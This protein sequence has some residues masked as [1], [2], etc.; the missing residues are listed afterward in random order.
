MNTTEHT[1]AGFIAEHGIKIDPAPNRRDSN[2]NMD[3]GTTMDHWRVTLRHGARRYTLTFSKGSGHKGAPPTVDEVLECIQ[4]DATYQDTPFEE[5][6]RE[7][8]FDDD[9]RKAERTY[10]A[11]IKQTERARALIGDDLWAAFLDAQP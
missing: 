4:S 8:G 9:S 11:V 7:L 10:N 3:G 1:L 2:P 5:W 6:A